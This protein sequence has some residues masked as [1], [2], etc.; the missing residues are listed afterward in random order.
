MMVAPPRI[1]E[2]PEP[3]HRCQFSNAQHALL[4]RRNAEHKPSIYCV[5]V[6]V[7][8]GQADEKWTMRV[9]ARALGTYGP[10]VGRCVPLLCPMFDTCDWNRN[11][12]SAQAWGERECAWAEKSES[13]RSTFSAIGSIWVIIII[14]IYISMGTGVEPEMWT[15]IL[16]NIWYILCR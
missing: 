6:C 12:S 8:V 15:C 5:R 7:V 10:V 11:E 13:V 4:V 16:Q 3:A 2:P 14:C 1:T 9:W